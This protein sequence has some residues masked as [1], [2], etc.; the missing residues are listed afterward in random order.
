MPQDASAPFIERIRFY[1]KSGQEPATKP[2]AKKPKHEPETER[3][4]A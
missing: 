4:K 1:A 2:V 3:A